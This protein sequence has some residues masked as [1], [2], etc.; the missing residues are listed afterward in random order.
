MNVASFGDN[1]ELLFTL[2]LKPDL[3]TFVNKPP[4]WEELPVI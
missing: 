3:F 2:I 4:K 1:G